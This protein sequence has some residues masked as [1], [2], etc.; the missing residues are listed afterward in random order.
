M[1]DSVNWVAFFDPVNFDIL[2][3]T[4]HSSGARG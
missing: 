4:I 3:L 1:T 2:A